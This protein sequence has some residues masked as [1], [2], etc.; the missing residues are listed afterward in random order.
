MRHKFIA[1]DGFFG[2]G[3]RFGQSVALDGGYALIGAPDDDDKLFESGSAYLFDANTGQ[4]LQKFT[5]PDGSEYD[6]FGF[7]VALEGSYALIGAYGS[8]DLGDDSGS[9]YLYTVIQSRTDFTD[10]G[11]PDILFHNPNGQNLYYDPFG[12]GW[13]IL[14]N[15]PGWRT[16]AIGN[17]RGDSRPEVVFHNPDTGQNLIYN[18]F[19]PVNWDILNNTP[20][21]WLPTGMGDFNGDGN[22][23]IL[24]HNPNTGQNW[25]YNP[26]GDQWS[27]LD[28]TPGWFPGG[29][30]DLT[31]DGSPDIVFYNVTTSENAI[32]DPIGAVKWQ[33]LAQVPG[34]VPGGVGD[35]NQDGNNDVIFHNPATGTNL[36]YNLSTADPNP[37]A[38][39][40]ITPG[41]A[42]LA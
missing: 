28:S 42:P 10:D 32:Y 16:S 17:L 36:Y 12:Q 27:I 31:G 1:P 8:D 25:T 20:G 11:K 29:V 5:A 23:D 33:P 7:S 19:A 14:N 39:L 9:A 41:W 40:N 35:F 13:F 38:M 4:M 21:G 22:N 30:G 6:S 34:W 37:W 18:H 24:Y 26:F 3:D 2:D 15:A